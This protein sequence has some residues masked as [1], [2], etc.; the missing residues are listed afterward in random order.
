M[1]HNTPSFQK[2]SPDS[3]KR[4]IIMQQTK[5]KKSKTQST[6]SPLS[7][8]TSLTVNRNS[9]TPSASNI[10]STP[11]PT[12]KGTN[13]KVRND[14][15]NIDVSPTMSLPVSTTPP[16]PNLVR[17]PNA[18]NI[19]NP[20]SLNKKIRL[21]TLNTESAKSQLSHVTSSNVNS[22]ITSHID[23]EQSSCYNFK[24]H[25]VINN[26][27]RNVPGV[28]LLDKFAET[29]KP[30]PKPYACPAIASNMALKMM[31]TP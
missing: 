31:N 8:I 18:Q 20:T 11:N 22:N 25:P 21:Q 27:T 17:K 5:K 6:S 28:N 1:E 24:F 2:T 12:N 9:N 26:F 10:C 30:A 29:T 14:T 3:R 15:Q 13:S 23:Q 4:R 19:Q 16:C 7:D